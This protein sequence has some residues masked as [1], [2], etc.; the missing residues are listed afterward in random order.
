VRAVAAAMVGALGC[1]TPAP[2]PVKSVRIATGPSVADV[3]AAAVP[4]YVTLVDFWSASCGACEV[5]GGR[6]A[7][8]IAGDPRVVIRIIDV[9]DGFTPVAQQNQINALPHIRIYDPT[10][11]RRAD[12]V[13]DHCLDAPSIAR[14][15]LAEQP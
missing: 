5:V 12:L 4:G 14:Q 3:D 6:I 15:L 9:G 10:R 13:G 1:A 2:P 7:T 11:R 8:A